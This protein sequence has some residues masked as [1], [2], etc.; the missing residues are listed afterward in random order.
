MKKTACCYTIL[1]S[2]LLTITC[3]A[4]PPIRWQKTYG[5]TEADAGIVVKQTS[6]GGLVILANSWSKDGDV[7]S[8]RG[9]T[10]IL[11]LRSDIS[12]N[13]LWQKTYGG[14]R[15]D[16]PTTLAVLNDGGFII[17]GATESKNGDFSTNNG[18]EDWFFLR[19]DSLGNTLWVKTYGG[20]KQDI[21]R[22]MDT[23]FEGNIFCVGLT[24]AD[25]AMTL[26]EAWIL[27]L[28]PA[29]EILINK[30]FGGTAFDIATGVQSTSDGGCVISG[31]TTSTDSI[32]AE[33]HGSSDGFV[34]KL[35]DTLG[36]EWSAFVG[37]ALKEELWT[38]QKLRD[39]HYLAAGY[40]EELDINFLATHIKQ[41]GE[42][43]WKK[44]FGGDGADNA[45]AITE[46]PTGGYQIIGNS[47]TQVGLPSDSL[48]PPHGNH[49]LL[50]YRIDTLGN[51]LF[52]RWF[53]GSENDFS[54]LSILSVF[55]SGHI[56][57]GTT[58]SSDGDV[59]SNHGGSDVWLVH[60]EGIPIS[61]VE[62]NTFEQISLYPNPA[63]SRLL[64]SAA[65]LEGRHYLL[66]TD[67]KGNEVQVKTM[68]SFD[69]VEFD[70]ST[71]PNGIY[72]I[73]IANGK[74]LVS[75]RKFIKE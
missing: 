66:L 63:H 45:R 26:G 6:D 30:N 59:T 25:F 54:G 57:T 16:I 34:F 15:H 13:L 9:A 55:P 48:Y 7:D 70:V 50:L 40:A 39:G 32:M 3:L 44:T 38:I 11:L 24:G 29:G 28:S 53:G 68:I 1:F 51:P 35:N 18:F 33:N 17:G 58:S 74:D 69:I 36:L 14:T 71:L 62:D 20:P 10:D 49:D 5:G 65:V 67:A 8:N 60:Y 46:V 21:L 56:I 27:K 64:V 31:H 47:T 41:N 19:L 23:D 12:G 2:L 22:A 4:Q 52:R 72:F 37:T 43:S 73:I 61:S 42:I 75:R